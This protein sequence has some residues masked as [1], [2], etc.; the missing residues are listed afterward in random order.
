MSNFFNYDNVWIQK[1]NKIADLL[2]LNIIWIFVSMPVVTVGAATTA[3]YYT[4]N[5]V[6]LKDEGSLWKAFWSAFKDNFKQSTIAWLTLLLLFA[7]TMMDGFLLYQYSRAGN[8]IGIFYVTF[9]IFG[10][11]IATW[12]NY[13]FSYIASFEDCTKT[14]MLNCG[15]ILFANMSW[16]ILLAALL[17]ISVALLWLF[18]MLFIIIPIVYMIISNKILKQIYKK[19]TSI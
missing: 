19:Y 17:G 1:L 9:T 18:P 10:I 6:I 4:I 13:L 8:S 15:K 2:I 11:I 14:T 5:K 12:G 16:S 7:I 3:V